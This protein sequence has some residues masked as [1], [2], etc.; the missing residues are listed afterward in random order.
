MSYYLADL[1]KIRRFLLSGRR[2]AFSSDPAFISA[3]SYWRRR[4][5]KNPDLNFD[6]LRFSTGILMTGA[7]DECMG[8]PLSADPTGDAVVADQAKIQLLL[9]SWYSTSD[10][11]EL[12][13]VSC[14]TIYLLRAEKRG[15]GSIR[16]SSALRLTDAY[17]RLLQGFIPAEV[18]ASLPELYTVRNPLAVHQ[19]AFTG[20][21]DFNRVAALLRD[22]GISA[23]RLSREFGI[24][25]DYTSAWRRKELSAETLGRMTFSLAVRYTAAYD[26]CHAD[27]KAK[28]RPVVLAV[29][30][31]GR[32]R[33]LLDS[34]VTA[35]QI[36]RVTG[37][38]QTEI[39]SYRRRKNQRDLLRISFR[40]ALR[41]TLAAEILLK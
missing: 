1:R 19:R 40:N 35:Y 7:Y 22:D 2:S 17:D 27:D 4:L 39:G 33:A 3:V 34:D 26:A 13:N 41:L 20:V 28:I 29:A 15:L 16:M 5:Q 24:G 32:I 37:I 11:A 25:S 36:A 30:D 6:N 10:L 18:Y 23:A 9:R 21:A 31:F 14:D 38:E 8:E 12:T